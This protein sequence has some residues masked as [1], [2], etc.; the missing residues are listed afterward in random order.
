M[1]VKVILRSGRSLFQ[2]HCKTAHWNSCSHLKEFSNS[3][4]AAVSSKLMSNN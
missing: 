1:S 2:Q 3:P 4:D